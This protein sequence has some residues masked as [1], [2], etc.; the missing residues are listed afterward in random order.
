[1][2]R[3]G[4]RQGAELGSRH[5][6]DANR[7]L[8][9]E[10]AADDSVSVPSCEFSGNRRRFEPQSLSEPTQKVWCLPNRHR[11]GFPEQVLC[12]KSSRRVGVVLPG[13]RLPVARRDAPIVVIRHSGRETSAAVFARATGKANTGNAL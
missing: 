6:V 9:G 2:L 10:Y 7:P 8:S 5:T 11:T 12:G 13:Y 4:N 3:R 1:M